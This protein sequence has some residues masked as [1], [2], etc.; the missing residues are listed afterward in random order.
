[1]LDPATIDRALRVVAD[2]ELA[3]VEDAG[4]NAAQP[5]EQLQLDGW[6]LRFS[7][8]KARRARSVN[9]IAA[10]RLDLDSKLELCGIHYRRA[11]LPLLFRI[12]PFSLPSDLD[13][14][15]HRRGFEAFDET[16]VMTCPLEA[17]LA[18]PCPRALEPVAIDA[19][20]VAEF[21]AIVG[22]MR[23]SSAWQVQAHDQRLRFSSLRATSI[24]RIVR[25]GGEPVAAGQAVIEGERAG[26]YDIVTAPAW[27]GRGL[28]RTLTAQ[29]LSD[30][31]AGGARTMYL[32]VDAGNA[33]ARRIYAA[34]GFIDRY[35]YWYRR[36]AGAADELMS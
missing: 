17:A 11:N 19:V 32:Q 27:R 36:P 2:P 26:L 4:L 25:V 22:A 10:G 1:M 9:A 31:R 8:G 28:G 6:L 12:T 23:G 18:A 7:P 35:V 29:L 30:A 20:E 14:F 34:L 21:A 33:A 15:L 13:E 3:R 5:A 24:R 16:R